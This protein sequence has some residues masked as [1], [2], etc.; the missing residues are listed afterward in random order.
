[1]GGK[2]K[3]FHEIAQV[4]ESYHSGLGIL[5]LPFV[6]CQCLAQGS[7]W[8]SRSA[9]S[10]DEIAVVVESFKLCLLLC[11]PTHCSMPGFPVLHCIPEFAQTHVHWD[12]DGIQ[13]SHPLSPPSLSA[14][15]LSQLSWPNE[16]ALHIRWPKF[17][18]CSKSCPLS[19]WYYLAHHILCHPLLLFS[20]SNFPSIRIFSNESVLWIRWPKYWIFSFSISPSN[21]YSG[22]ISFGIDCFDVLAVQGT[23]KSLF[24]YHSLKESI[25]QWWESEDI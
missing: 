25:L 17:W 16:S 21:E 22:L 8:I 19:Q 10:P 23:L 5:V 20:P 24:Q 15:N 7:L 12:S 11:D 2:L 4:T 13:P 9:M 14:V 6:N 1:M 3:V 18:I